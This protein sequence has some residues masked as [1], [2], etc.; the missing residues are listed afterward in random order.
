MKAKKQ[1]IYGSKIVDAAPVVRTVY[2]N[3]NGEEVIRFNGTEYKLA[4]LE[5]NE[6]VYLVICEA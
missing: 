5:K 3:E 4:D 1:V 6:K 2:K